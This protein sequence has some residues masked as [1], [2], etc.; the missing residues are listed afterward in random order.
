MLSQFLKIL[1][2]FSALFFSTNKTF[3]TETLTL[4]FFYGDGCPHCSQEEKFLK[5]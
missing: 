3:A 2:I 4:K 1:F 5:N